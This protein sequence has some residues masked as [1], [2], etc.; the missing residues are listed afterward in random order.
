MF[1]TTAGLPISLPEGDTS[2]Y[3]IR[4]TVPS[5]IVVANT[6]LIAFIQGDQNREIAQ[7]LSITSGTVKVH[8]MH[9][10]EKAGVSDR[11]ELAVQGEKLLGHEQEDV[12]SQGT[13]EGRL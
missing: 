11:F 8:L 1:P 5:P 3:S 9:I 7:A 4:F 2:T 13:P 6:H 12:N 10:F